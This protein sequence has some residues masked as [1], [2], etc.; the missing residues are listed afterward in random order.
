MQLALPESSWTTDSDVKGDLFERVSM[1]LMTRLEELE[2]HSV[3]PLRSLSSTT[4]GFNKNQ[5]SMME[6]E[7]FEMCVLCGEGG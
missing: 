6:T 5:K 7:K 2:N 4:K 1:A 3:I